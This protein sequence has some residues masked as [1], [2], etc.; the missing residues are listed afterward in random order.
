MFASSPGRC[1]GAVSALRREH[2][3]RSATRARGLR[4]EAT[5]TDYGFRHGVVG[6]S[7]SRPGWLAD[8]ACLTCVYLSGQ[9]NKRNS[10]R[11]KGNIPDILKQPIDRGAGELAIVE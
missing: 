5:A 11:G 4:Q 7:G 10:I 8:V 2:R 1:K 6:R 3:C 9:H